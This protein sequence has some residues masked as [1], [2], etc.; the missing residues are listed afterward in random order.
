MRVNL[1]VSEL[2]G[3]ALRQCVL[4]APRF[5]TTTFLGMLGTNHTQ[6]KPQ[7]HRRKSLKLAGYILL[8]YV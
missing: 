7:I 5:E 2:V 4:S 6:Q 8:Q 3:V 1:E